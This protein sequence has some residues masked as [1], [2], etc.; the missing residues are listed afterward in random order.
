ME[1]SEYR[2]Q[3]QAV[4]SSAALIRQLKLHDLLQAMNRAET[5]GP[6]LDPTLYLKSF[7]SLGWQKR[8]VEA[9]LKFQQEIEETFQIQNT[10]DNERRAQ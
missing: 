9:T 2:I 1:Q 7:T 4:F 5:L 3:L 10:C 8:I 6:I